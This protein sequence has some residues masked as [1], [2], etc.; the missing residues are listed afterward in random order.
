MMIS[1]IIEIFDF[2]YQLLCNLKTMDFIPKI[3]V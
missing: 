1:N 2:G 3:S